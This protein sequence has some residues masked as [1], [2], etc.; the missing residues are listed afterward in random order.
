VSR[1]VLWDAGTLVAHSPGLAGLSPD[2]AARIHP[3]EIERLGLAGAGQ[4]TLTSPKGTLTLDLKAD[5]TVPA[6]RASVPFNLAGG[7]AAALID[8]AAS[9]TA[10]SVAR[11]SAPGR[12]DDPAPTTP[13]AGGES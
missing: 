2:W 1:R 9:G 3:D 7:S 11:A 13:V 12:A 5:V 8:S 6:G 10:V 4:V